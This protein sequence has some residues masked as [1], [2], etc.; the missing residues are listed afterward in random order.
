[1][2]K[3]NIL[4]EMGTDLDALIDRA[5]KAP[6][7]EVRPIEDKKDV[8]VEEEHRLT[9]MIPKSMFTKIKQ[10]AA[11]EDISIKKL[12]MDIFEREI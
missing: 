1:M 4:S 3:K 8:V 11:L 6:I 7:Q 12:C 10:R 2:A 5:P 9:I